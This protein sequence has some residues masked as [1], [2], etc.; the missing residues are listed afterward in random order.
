M[1]V[2]ITMPRSLQRVL[3]YNEQKVKKGIAMCIGGDNF[4]GEANALNC[5]QKLVIFQRRFELNDRA[6]TKVI[7]ISLNFDPS[8]SFGNKKLLDIASDY[9]QKIGFGGQPSLV[10]RHQDTL[11]PH[12]HIVSTTIRADGSRINTHNLGRNQSSKAR[13][14]IEEEY[15]LVKAQSRKKVVIPLQVSAHIQKAQYGKGE[16]R[17]TMS[18]IIQSVASSFNYTSLAEFNAALRLYNVTPDAGTESDNIDS[19]KGLHYYIL[20][21]SGQKTGVGIRA[22]SL[23]GK[24][25]TAWLEKRYEENKSSRHTFNARLKQTLDSVLL[26]PPSDFSMFEKQLS[27]L[28]VAI[29]LRTNGEGRHYGITFIDT[30]NKSVFNGSELGKEY[31]ITSLQKI[32]PFSA[33]PEQKDTPQPLLQKT[34]GNKPERAAKKL[35]INGLGNSVTISLLRD[36]L[37]PETNQDN[38]PAALLQKKGK[39]KKKRKHS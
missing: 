37:T 5:Y 20:T 4:L 23:L 6:S 17:D 14:E 25:V 30:Q 38:I 27:Q 19:R 1:V 21:D 9:M 35:D 34:K 29:L 7:H 3:N 24:P 8:E 26:R 16:T 31:S 11:H 28:G 10:Y 13:R 36:L 39:R 15:R 32:V 33:A 18:R 22:N 2:K 12:V